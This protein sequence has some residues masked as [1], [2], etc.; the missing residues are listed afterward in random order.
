MFLSVKYYT[1]I[2]FEENFLINIIS[3][4]SYFKFGLIKS[5]Y[6]IILYIRIKTVVRNKNIETLKREELSYS[7]KK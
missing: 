5:V 3:Y 1:K 7:I 6:L 4:N 2:N